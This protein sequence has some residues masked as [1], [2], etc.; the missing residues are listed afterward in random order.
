MTVF[1][2]DSPIPF[3]GQYWYHLMSDEMEGFEE[4][5]KFARRVGLRS[6]WFHTDHY[7]VTEAKRRKAI[8]LG[9][10]SCKSIHLVEIRKARRA[11]NG[12]IKSST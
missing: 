3:R 4:L 7:D 11:Y 1:V 12:S 5:H 9:A 2:D 8:N 10:V 6:D